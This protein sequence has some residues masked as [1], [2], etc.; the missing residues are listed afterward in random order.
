VNGR[1]ALCFDDPAMADIPGAQ[2]LVHVTAEHIFPNC[3]RYIPHL[4]V[5]E[6][7]VYLPNAEG[8]PVEPA[9]KGFEIFKDV[10]PP[11]TR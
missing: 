8:A 1:A 3:P 11:R 4:E 5:K 2:A 10:V 7:S 6:E 9:W